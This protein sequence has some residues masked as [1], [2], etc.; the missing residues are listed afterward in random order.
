MVEYEESKKIYKRSAENSLTES[1]PS[2][3]PKEQT[4]SEMFLPRKVA[5]TPTSKQV[6]EKKILSY[7]ANA[8]L[9]LSIVDGEKFRDLLLCE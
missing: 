2:K 9:P 4:I 7:V 3:K 6:L 5:Y 8:L 1:G